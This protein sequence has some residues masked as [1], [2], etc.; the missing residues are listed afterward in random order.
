MSDENKKSRY[1]EAQKK[2]AE[3]YLANFDDIK[4][5]VIHGGR[6]VMKEYATSHGWKSLNECM[7]NL[8][9]YAMTNNKTADDFKI[10]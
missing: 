3:R 4:L 6:D 9:N 1:T 2:S 8:I 7:I 5:R 10:N